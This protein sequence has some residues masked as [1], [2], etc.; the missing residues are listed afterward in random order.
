[1]P[2]VL[3]NRKGPQAREPSKCLN[4]HSYGERLAKEAFWWP[5]TGGLRKDSE[6]A[7]TP[8]KEAVHVPAHL[9]PREFPQ[10]KL[11]CH[12][13][14][15]PSLGQ[16][17]H[18]Q[19]KVLRLCTQGC[20]SPTLCDPVD[21]GLPG[22]SVREGVLQARIQECFGQVWLPYPSRAHFLLP[23]PLST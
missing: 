10:A 2:D 3:N 21:Y 11:L 23:T 1:M 19:K 4:E 13:H 15:Q 22:F 14:A 7:I 17:Y 5:A 6:R 20:F 18:R 9:V 16:S 8:A 12:L